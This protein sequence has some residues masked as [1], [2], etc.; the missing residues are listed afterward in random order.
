MSQ[1]DETV[2]LD[3][4]QRYQY[5]RDA[6]H[7]Q[8]IL[9]ADRCED[10]FA[11]LQWEQADLD[12]LREERRPA[13]TINKIISTL[14]TIQGEQ[15]YN[16]TETS[17]RPRGTS[18]EAIADTLTKVY[19]QISDNNQLTWV[20]SDV[21]ADGII[22]SRGF[23]DA[24]IEF[25]DSMAGE[26]RIGLLN[27]KNV[28]IDPDAED[29]DPDT[30]NDV[31]ITK[32]LTPGDISMAYGE[33]FGKEFKNRATS[34]FVYGFDSI[35]RARDR[36][37]K[38]EALHGYSQIM[39]DMS[40][41]RNVRVLERQFF[42][43]DMVKH[44]VD[45][46]NGDMRPVPTNWDRNRIALVVQ[47][48][49]VQVISR[50][51]RRVRWR[52]TAD[53]IVLHDDFAP[54]KHFTPVPYF[55]HFRHGRTIGLVENLLGSQELLNKVSSQ[56]LHVV[57]SSANS[58]WKVKRGALMNM[59]VE[60]LEMRGA[61][62]GLVLEMQDDLGAAEKI[63]PNSTPQGLDRIS[64]K[65]EEHIKTISSVSDSMSGFDREDVAAR[66]IEAK[67]A[68]GAVNL[69]K[70][71][72]NLTRTDFILARNILDMVQAFYS[73]ERILNITKDRLTGAT[74]S[75]TINEVTPEGQILNDLT[76]GEF[77]V[78]I[79][80]APARVTFEDSQFEQAMSLRE[81]GIGI[82]DS[83]IIENS[84]LARKSEVLKQMA[85]ANETPEAQAAAALEQRMKEATVAKAEAD[86]ANAMA[87]AEL[88]RAKAQA[89]L[90]ATPTDGAAGAD[91]ERYRIDREHELARE[92]MEREFA[93]KKEAA[94]REFT[95]KQET[96][97]RESLMKRAEAVLKPAAPTTH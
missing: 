61:Q 18:A 74:E 35:E 71:M 80:S 59:T 37:S 42:T 13:L 65:A 2:A 36:F 88:K 43:H 69:S 33:D 44:F 47:Q 16:R 87:D 31:F 90:N 46:V 77:D 45:P 63:Q 1:S 73:E 75:I 96:A 7:S 5:C 3:Q 53:N 62:S 83:V 89:E 28:V 60:E 14:S 78:I 48:T 81:R 49:G 79:T 50:L 58:G 91:L 22:R 21:F 52:V 85:A 92:K 84:Q 19:M 76:I 24:R 34:G 95:L 27:S 40:A 25:N 70:P 32:W 64:Y 15:L 10:F 86:A 6:G 66:A 38:D 41:L 20:R 23:Y 9:K 57:N 55:P 29:Y 93:L 94:E 26:V 72:D 54:Y 17:F 11:G 56:E 39:S 67:Q 68:R 97:R 12:A 51:T 82:P 4:W 30:W 8:F